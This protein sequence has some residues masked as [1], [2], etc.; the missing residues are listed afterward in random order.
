MDLNYPGPL[1]EQWL[2][3]DLGSPKQVTGIVTQGSAEQQMWVTVEPTTGA[4]NVVSGVGIDTSQFTT[5]PAALREAR[6]L[7]SQGQ[8]AQ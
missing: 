1:S 6:K 8:A 5:L 3:V 4:A 7:A 2:Q